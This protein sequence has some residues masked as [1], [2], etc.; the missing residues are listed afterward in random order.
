[1]P[2]TILVP[3]QTDLFVPHY[4]PMRLGEWELRVSSMNLVP[5]YWS[6]ADAGIAATIADFRLPLV[7]PALPDYTAKVA[8]VAERW[9]NGRWL[10]AAD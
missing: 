6:G 10:P 5:G 7:G 4:R 8:L 3:F 1:M 9:M 2:P